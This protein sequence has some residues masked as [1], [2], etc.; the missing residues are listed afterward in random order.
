MRRYAG[1]PRWLLIVPL[2]LGV[3]CIGMRAEPRRKPTPGHLGIIFKTVDEAAKAACAYVWKHEHRA[4]RIEFCGVIYRDAEGIKAGLPVTNDEAGRCTG[5][6]EPEGTEA[7]ASYHNH[8]ETEEFSFHDRT[9]PTLLSMYLC[10]PS[11]LV[12]RRTPD[13]TVIV[14]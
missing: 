14:K 12:K 11:G 7:E 9:N 4:T 2:L 13:G 1:L 6:F 5:P 10:T 8:K 3:G